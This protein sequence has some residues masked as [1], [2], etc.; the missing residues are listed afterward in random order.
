MIYNKYD[1]IDA[2]L[3]GERIEFKYQNITYIIDKKLNDNNYQDDDYYLYDTA[4]KSHQFFDSVDNLINNAKVGKRCLCNV[5]DELEIVFIDY[6]TKK[7]FIAA[8]LM[9]REIEFNYNGVEYFRSQSDKGYYIWCKKDDSIQYYQTPEELLECAVLE[10]E[11]L[12]ELW[13][14]INISCIL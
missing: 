4:T 9:N 8:N 10:G 12:K 11:P 7:E 5:L 6:N 1:F 3:T 13:D 2:C 14:K